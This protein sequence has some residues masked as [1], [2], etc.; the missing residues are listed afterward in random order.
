M[1]PKNP[2]LTIYPT[3]DDLVQG[4][5]ELT[6]ALAL[7]AVEA[8]GRFTVAL[9]GGG[10]PRPVYS[11]LTEPDFANRIPWDKV[12]VFF[13]D[14]RCVPPTDERSNYRMAREALLQHVPLP[15]ANIHRIGGEDDPARAALAYEQD[16]RRFFRTGSPPAFDLIFLGLGENGHTAS[17]F[18]GTASLREDERWVVPQYVEITGTWRVTMT[19]PLI[20]AARYV[21]FMVTGSEKA[22]VLVRILEGHFEPDVLPAQMVLPTNGQIRWLVDA[23]A[24]ARVLP[25]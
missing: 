24:G 8:R 18:P 21:V 5:A 15:P 4:A 19:L 13:G 3:P 12:H 7:T 6:T 20:N 16:M 10:T 2:N 14:E 17:L 25:E 1:K 23:A 9:A 11:L 22:D